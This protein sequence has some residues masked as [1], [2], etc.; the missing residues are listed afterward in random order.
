MKKILALAFALLMLIASI[1]G[2]AGTDAGPGENTY[3]LKTVKEGY[4]TVITSPDY[5]PYEFYAL[6]ADGNPSLAGFDMALAQYIADYLGLTLEVIPMDF[7][8][9]IGEMS[10]GAADLAMAGLSPDPDRET[11]MTFSDIYYEGKQAFIT[12]KA[13]A[14]KFADLEATNKSEFTFAAQT[15]TIQMELAKKFSPNAKIVPLMKATD[16][17]AELMSGKLQGAYVEWDVAAAYQANYPDLHIAFEVPNEESEGNVIGI[18]KGNTA[19]VNH[20][21]AALHK[22]ID[23]GTF[24]Q[25]VAKAQEQAAGASYEGLL[26]ENGNVPGSSLISAEGFSK[27]FRYSKAIAEGLAVTVMLA[28]FT[29]VIGFVLGIL[30]AILRMT[31]IRP[32]R[33]L[34]YGKKGR[35]QSSKLLLAISKFNP[36]SFLATAYVEILRSTPVIVQIM[37]IYHGVFSLIKLPSFTIFG[38]IHFDRFFPGVVALGMNSAA[39]L[40]EIIRSGIQSIDGG[41]AEAAR[42]LGMTKTQTMA[43]IILPQA[44]KNILP[45]IANEFVVI[46]K[47][48]SITYTIGV[49]DLMSAVQAVQGANYIIMEPLLVAT[50][51]YFC[52]CFP[53][54]K[55]I[56]YFERRMSRGDK[57]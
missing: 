22:C 45:A 14:E 12:T 49:Q 11:A 50:A 53:S 18:N 20:V 36:V 40:C 15:G 6:D 7:N 30:L 44:I 4:L 37:L 48:S 19:L 52:L 56:A 25:Y 9:I 21:N 10:A 38:F 51:I 39:Y 46:I 23:E 17:I 54:S 35:I 2:C 55:L 29:V 33:F 32:F 57:R 27:T 1:S 41:Q 3:N 47:E 24:S 26:D 5:S 16:I 8:G 42:S 43:S 28:L 34:A 31:D 13:N